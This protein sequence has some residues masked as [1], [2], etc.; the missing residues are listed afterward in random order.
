MKS[1]QQLWRERVT[2]MIDDDERWAGGGAVA[3]RAALSPVGQLDSG[4]APPSFARACRQSGG[5]SRLLY[6]LIASP[7]LLVEGWTALVS[8]LS[9]FQVFLHRHSF[10]SSAVA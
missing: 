5:D 2:R 1:K 3:G 8:L 6:L 9:L 10:L 4:S 7:A